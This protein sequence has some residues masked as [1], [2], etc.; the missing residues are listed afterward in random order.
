L[1]SGGES[2]QESDQETQTSK[3]SSGKV[4]FGKRKGKSRAPKKTK[5]S[6]EKRKPVTRLDIFDSILA[7]NNVKDDDDGLHFM[8]YCFF[9]DWNHLCEY[10]QERWRDYQD[11]LS[12]LATVSVMANTAFELLQRPRDELF[13]QIPVRGGLRDYRN[14]ANMLFYIIGLAHVTTMRRMCCMEMTGRRWMKPYTKKPIGSAWQGTGTFLNG[15]K[16]YPLKDSHVSTI[17]IIRITH[18]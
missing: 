9:K 6:L 5:K 4:R 10:V 7:E 15:S 2:N 16:M 1:I 8:V 13:S 14:L 3:K 17:E 11:G 18:S 12:S